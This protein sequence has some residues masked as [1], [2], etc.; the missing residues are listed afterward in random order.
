MTVPMNWNIKT[1]FLAALCLLAFVKSS[2]GGEPWPQE[3]SDLKPDAKATYGRLENG[4]RYVIYPNKFPVAERA[5]V[6]LFMDVG[7]L[8]EETDQRGMAHFLEHMA[9]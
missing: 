3:Q 6:R 9:F 7:S 1:C 4:L 8:M 5:S 2:P